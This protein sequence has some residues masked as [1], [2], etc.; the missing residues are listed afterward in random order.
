ML[1]NKQIRL[2]SICILV[3]SAIQAQVKL[4]GEIGFHAAS[5]IEKNSLPGWDTSMPEL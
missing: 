2:L 4:G 3:C 5:V 1:M